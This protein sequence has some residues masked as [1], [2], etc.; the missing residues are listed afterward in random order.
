MEDIKNLKEID[1]YFDNITHNELD[2][3]LE[4]YIN[5]E[6]NKKFEDIFFDNKLY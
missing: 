6:Y 3:K 4:K 1:E 5:E 2:K